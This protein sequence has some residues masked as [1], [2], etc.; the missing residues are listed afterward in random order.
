MLPELP[1]GA[2]R[3]VHATIEGSDPHIGTMLHRT[4]E[5]SILRPDATRGWFWQHEL[6]AA[7]RAGMVNRAEYYEWHTYLPCECKPPL[8][9]MT[10]LYDERLEIGK[11]TAQGKAYKLVYN[12]AYGKFAQSVGEPPYANPIYASLIT[13]GCRTMILDAI[14]THPRKTAAVVMVAT[15]GVYFT[16]EHPGLPISEKLGQWGVEEKENLTL[17]KP[18][19]YWDDSTREDIRQKRNPVFKTRGVNAESFAKVIDK[20][21]AQF[22]DW[23][24]GYPESADD[25]PA[26]KFT[27]GFSMVSAKQALQWHKWSQAG[28]VTSDKQVTQ[29]SY[30][31]DKR[32]PGQYDNGI[33][34][35]T[36][37]KLTRKE[38][39]AQNSV[40]YD[41]SF[42]SA[43]MYESGKIDKEQY[44]ITPDGLAIDGWYDAI[45]VRE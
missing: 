36:P 19:V 32:D 45:G 42:G 3:L 9:G 14:A 18:G 31:D 1:D 5:Q 22:A 37:K 27:L 6:D 44:G 30:P 28:S 29:R 10:G 34:R 26:V 43:A 15:D 41:K 7:C 17:F 21:D 24:G 38:G 35:S 12:S 40:P 23:D 13:A 11:D 20:V 39:R 16:S 33:Y 8:R 25:W 2:Y 4:L